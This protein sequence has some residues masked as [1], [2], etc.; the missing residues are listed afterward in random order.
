MTL[1]TR[2]FNQDPKK[3][4]K[5]AQH[6]PVFIT[7]CGCPAHVLLTI[8]QYQALTGVHTTIVDLLAQPVGAF[9]SPYK[10]ADLS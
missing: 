7:D 3:A 1:T 5:A 6:G 4:R 9:D 8:E 10:P 2:E